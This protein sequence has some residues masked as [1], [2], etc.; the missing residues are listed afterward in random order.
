MTALKWWLRIVGSLY[1]LEGI[2]LTAQA[3]FDPDAFAATWTSTPV[4]AL[5]GISVRGLV[6]AGLPGV[7]TWV[8]LGSLMWIYS[9]MPAKAGLLIVVVAAWELLVWA[10]T[11]IVGFLNGF[12]LP[13]A[14]A[15][16]TIHALIGI[17][18]IF[19]VRRM[20][21]GIPAS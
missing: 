16:L 6:V 1:L 4:G 5:D 2:G 7:L 17:S 13:R 19:V 20:P 11:D 3:L 21:H 14:V 12:E 8:L 18:G 15:L 9:R 10:P